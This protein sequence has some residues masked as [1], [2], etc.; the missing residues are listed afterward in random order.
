M[1]TPPLSRSRLDRATARRRDNAWLARAWADPASRVLVLDG[2]GRAPI[3]EQ[4]EAPE[5]GAGGG[6]GAGGDREDASGPALALVAPGDLRDAGDA[7]RAAPRAGSGDQR[8][9]GDTAPYG[10]SRFLL[11]VDDAGTAYW[12]VVGT[13]PRRPG[14]RHAGLRDVGALLPDRDA[15]M[16]VAAVAL[17]NWH[18]T[19]RHCPRCGAETVVGD[20]GHVR[21]CPV[22]DSEHFPR[23]DPAVIMLVSD[24]A[25]RCLLGRQ[26]SWPAGRFSTLAGFVEP[27]ESAEQAVTREVGEETGIAV[28][29][30]TYAAS[31]PWP[32]PASLM[33]GFFATADP[34]APVTLGDGELAEARWFHRE[35][36]YDDAVLLPGPTSIAR[37]LIETWRE[38][39]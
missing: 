39:G 20:A 13:P 29:D 28:R 1:R 2:R 7:D 3:D 12:G 33:L 22:D 21:R 36:T 11:G 9:P 19:H 14:L 37:G 24:G 8:R 23:T 27:G 30:V 26:P 31:Q 15:G 4:A 35:E 17:A 18:A 25:D 34:D 5:P 16:L 6:H 38:G 10:G 32:F